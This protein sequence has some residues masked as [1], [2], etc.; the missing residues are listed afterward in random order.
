MFLRHG[1]S[2]SSSSLIIMLGR[3]DGI[4]YG[5]SRSQVVNLMINGMLESFIIFC[6]LFR[7]RIF[8]RCP[9]N[10]TSFCLSPGFEKPSLHFHELLDSLVWTVSQ[11][12][13]DAKFC[14][15]SHTTSNLDTQW[16][17]SSLSLYAVLSLHFNRSRWSHFRKWINSPNFILWHTDPEL[18]R[19]KFLWM[20]QS[21][22]RRVKIMD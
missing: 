18:W 11:K 6:L 8:L 17:V 16:C 15:V 12:I 10:L 2:D 21:G 9:F 22:N 19:G 4:P 20:R 7:Y 5:L 13:L 14:L 1:C 3:H